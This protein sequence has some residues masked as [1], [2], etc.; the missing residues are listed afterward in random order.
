MG[1]EDSQNCV[2]KEIAFSDI[3]VRDS[4]SIRIV[5]ELSYAVCIGRPS[6]TWAKVILTC[7]LRKMDESSLFRMLART[8]SIS[9]REKIITRQ[10]CVL[11]KS[12]GWTLMAPAIKYTRIAI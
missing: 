3:V 4:N 9:A 6:M 11:V 8:L 12:R 10:D 1:S 2:A 5:V 7:C